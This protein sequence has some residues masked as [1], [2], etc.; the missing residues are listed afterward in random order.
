[1]LAGVAAVVVLAGC[2]EQRDAY[3]TNNPDGQA[4]PPGQLVYRTPAPVETD[5]PYTTPPLV[6]PLPGPT[7][8]VPGEVPTEA[9]SASPGEGNGAET[10]QE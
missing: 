2:S 7:G 4:D 5:L 3:S 8:G 10:D 6:V 9:G 1:L